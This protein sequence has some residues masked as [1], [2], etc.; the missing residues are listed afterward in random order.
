MTPRDRYAN[1]K[2][3]SCREDRR[4]T[5]ATST[6]AV[7]WLEVRDPK[8]HPQ[9]VE[10]SPLVA[11]VGIPSPGLHKATDPPRLPAGELPG[12][13]AGERPGT[14]GM[15]TGEFAASRLSEVQRPRLLGPA[16]REGHVLAAADSRLI[17]VGK[18]HAVAAGAQ[19]ALCGAP[20]DDET[21]TRA[22][23]AGM[24]RCPRCLALAPVSIEGR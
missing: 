14:R 19:Y 13:V 23:T 1:G 2:G 20:V 3:H 7:G 21:T 18:A 17:G 10:G 15:V 9:D 22:W 8:L 12:S 16:D 11:R 5:S 4:I 24:N 6:R